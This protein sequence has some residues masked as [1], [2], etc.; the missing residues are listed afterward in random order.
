MVVGVNTCLQWFGCS[1]FPH[2]R[3]HSPALPRQGKAIHGWQCMAWFGRVCL[4]LIILR[5]SFLRPFTRKT[6]LTMRIKFFVH[7][8]MG[9]GIIM[10]D[11]P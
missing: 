10:V 5:V 8:R 2:T 1:A 6:E 9:Y 4:C 3:A 11:W 7:V